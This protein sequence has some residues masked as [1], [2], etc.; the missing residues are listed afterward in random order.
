MDSE[1]IGNSAAKLG[2]S[3]DETF[4]QSLCSKTEHLRLEGNDRKGNGTF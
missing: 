1:L 2:G 4:P 3:F